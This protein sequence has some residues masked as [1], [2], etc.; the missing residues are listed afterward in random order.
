MHF[1]ILA[2][3]TLKTHYIKV[4]KIKLFSFCTLLLLDGKQYI[5]IY[6]YMREIDL[7]YSNLCH[8]NREKLGELLF[9]TLWH[10]VCMLHVPHNMDEWIG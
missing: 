4:P 3:K 10:I 7:I 9:V 6:I 2:L 8:I 1:S 5:Y